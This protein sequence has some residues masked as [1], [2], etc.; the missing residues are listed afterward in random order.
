MVHIDTCKYHTYR[1]YTL[2]L[3]KNTI[4]A[5]RTYVTLAPLNKI[6]KSMF[7]SYF[8]LSFKLSLVPVYQDHTWDDDIQLTYFSSPFDN[9][10]LF[11]P[12][13]SQPRISADF[14]QLSISKAKSLLKR[15]KE[16]PQATR[17]L[18]S[19][20]NSSLPQCLISGFSDT[21]QSVYHYQS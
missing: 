11:I 16:H 19:L 1:Q 12:C 2:V 20:T 15:E 13:P 4:A 5:F 7:S 17:P 8:S 9:S 6:A 21:S 10:S 3:M 18:K 14:F